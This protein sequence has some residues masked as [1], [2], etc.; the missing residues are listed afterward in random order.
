MQGPADW[1]NQSAWE[2]NPIPQDQADQIRTVAGRGS[3][4]VS[5]LA[6]VLNPI[7]TFSTLRQGGTSDLPSSFGPQPTYAN[8]NDRLAGDTQ[9]IRDAQSRGLLK[10]Q[11]TKDKFGEKQIQ[12]LRPSYKGSP[13]PLG[14]STVAGA[15]AKGGPVKAG[16]PYL[17]GEEGPE[18][19]VPDEDG[20]VIAN[21]DLKKKKTRK[22][23][24][25][26][27]SKK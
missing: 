9:A 15:R 27:L 17:V 12:I 19:V 1:M 26:A 22:L 11:R 8:A 10:T 18:I 20:E 5:R 24:Q 13:L 14:S 3:D 6:Q 25:A 23:L 7:T 21:K 16:E 2:Y 4:A